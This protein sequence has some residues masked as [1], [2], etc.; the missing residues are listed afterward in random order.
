MAMSLED[1]LAEEGF[2]RRKSKIVSR[3]SYTSEG[4]PSVPVRGRHEASSSLTVKKVERSRSEIP[5]YSSKGEASTS[6]S[7]NGRKPRDTFI[8]R[9]KKIDSESETRKND[10]K[11]KRRGHQDLWDGARFNVRASADSQVSEI[12]ELTQRYEILRWEITAHTTI[13]T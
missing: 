10:V 3:T 11:V 4:R 8:R 7:F 5:R 13:F 6:N 9:E 12:I 2:H 1:L